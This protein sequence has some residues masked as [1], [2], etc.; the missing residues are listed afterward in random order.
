MPSLCLQLTSGGESVSDWNLPLYLVEHAALSD[1]PMAGSR[2][3]SYLDPKK[4]PKIM[5]RHRCYCT[6][7]WGPGTTQ[8]LR[9]KPEAW[10]SP[11]MDSSHKSTGNTW[12]FLQLGGSSLWL[13]LYSKTLLFVVYLKVP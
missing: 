9:P 12:L 8:N 13:S 5:A 1:D 4:V 7:C 11:S 2:V 3:T 6:Y 10:A